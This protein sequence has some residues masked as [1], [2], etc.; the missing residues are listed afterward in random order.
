M[1]SIGKVDLPSLEE[2][3]IGSLK[4]LKTSKKSAKVASKSMQISC[5]T[6]KP[7]KKKPPKKILKTLREDELE[8]CKKFAENIEK[9]KNVFYCKKCIFS[10]MTELLA[11]AHVRSCGKSSKKGRPKK[12]SPCLEC[13]LEFS[14]MKVLRKHHRKEHIC[15]QYICSTC[16]RQFTHRPAYIRHIKIH[17]ELPHLE[18]PKT[19][20]EMKF[21]YNCNLNRHIAVHSKEEQQSRKVSEYSVKLWSSFP[22]GYPCS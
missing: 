9:R 3:N 18:C 12:L 16:L 20:C 13:G 14:S 1:E 4:E 21:R 7:A 8:G 6:N 17:R 15:G 22:R 11:R 2:V 10:T 5:K 19:G